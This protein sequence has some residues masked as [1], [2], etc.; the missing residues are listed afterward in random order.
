MKKVMVGLDHGA[1]PQ[2]TVAR[3]IRSKVV[4][5]LAVPL[6]RPVVVR[7]DR[8]TRPGQIGRMFVVGILEER[9]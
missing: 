6:V 1:V 7:E 4:A 5:L 9:C 3:R 2:S 8:E